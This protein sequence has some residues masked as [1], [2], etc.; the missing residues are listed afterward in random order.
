MIQAWLYMHQNGRDYLYLDL[1]TPAR[2][3]EDECEDFLS[4]YGVSLEEV[5]GQRGS[6]E[7]VEARWA[8]MDYLF[9]KRRM[10]KSEIGRLLNRDRTTVMHG[11]QQYARLAGQPI[12]R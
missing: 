9:H 12:K 8:L 6:D 10:S 5:R 7:V 2:K 4:E 3:R 1:R 11:V